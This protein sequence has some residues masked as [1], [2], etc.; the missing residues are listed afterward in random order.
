M[1]N[2]L[3]KYITLI[4]LF[5]ALL[6]FAFNVYYFFIR[7]DVGIGFYTDK[8]FHKAKDSV[9]LTPEYTDLVDEYYYLNQ[10]LENKPVIVFLGDSLTKRA[11]VQEYFPDHF[12]LNRGIDSDTTV[13]LL[14]RLDSN[15]GNLK[16]DKLF[17]LI[18][19]NDLQY[20]TNSE[21]AA[22]IKLVLGRIKARKIYLQSLIPVNAKK[23]EINSRIKEI[24]ELL[25]KVCSNT[26]IE[27]IDLHKHFLDEAGGLSKKHSIDGAHLNGAGYRI[28]R[29]LIAGKL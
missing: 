17:L 15:V 24:N 10:G 3:I 12:V 26:G 2:L 23:K 8:V 25:R 20:R 29:D 21:I 28:W 18:G 4:S 9:L 1:S 5:V 16:I 6:L 27:F 22:N 19:H 11:N 14:N 7:R 13:S